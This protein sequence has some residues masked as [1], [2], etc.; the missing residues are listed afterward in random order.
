MTFE[1]RIGGDAG[2]L[3]LERDGERVRWVLPAP[4]AGTLSPEEVDVTDALDRAYADVLV[5]SGSD[6]TE[7]LLRTGTETRLEPC[8]GHLTPVLVSRARLE[9]R[10]AVAKANLR[11]GEWTVRV[12]AAVAGFSP[13][14][15]PAVHG[16][17]P[18]RAPLVMTVTKDGR[19]VPPNLRRDVA[20]RFPGVARAFRRVRAGASG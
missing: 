10:I 5:S 14:T 7:Y 16:R 11:R 6:G 18:L 3:R 19:L 1:T 12:N 13:P 17:R 2:P 15:V 8:D 4:L 20:R 9:P